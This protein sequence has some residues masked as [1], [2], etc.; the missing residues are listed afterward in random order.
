MNNKGFT[1][2]EIIVIVMI[3]SI[4]TAIAWPSYKR[5]IAETRMSQG[6]VMARNTLDQMKSFYLTNS[7]TPNLYEFSE[8]LDFPGKT[9]DTTACKVQNV[10]NGSCTCTVGKYAIFYKVTA[11]TKHMAY[12][13][14]APN[15]V[16]N[17]Q[18]AIGVGF[19]VNT[20]NGFYPQMACISKNASSVA[21]A[22]CKEYSEDAL[23]E[24]GGL[25]WYA[26]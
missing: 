24:D 16:S 25:A 7:R 19:Y 15:G 9:C 14:F 18:D 8:L 23:V 13:M 21:T 20:A 22:M 6:T 5:A 26:M 17:E 12:F 2:T 10:P 11:T 1:L 3:L 4:L